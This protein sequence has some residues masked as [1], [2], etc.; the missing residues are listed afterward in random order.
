MKYEPPSHGE[1]QDGESIFSVLDLHKLESL[2][3]SLG[4]MAVNPPVRDSAVFLQER[5]KL[6]DT[7]DLVAPY[8]LIEEAHLE[9]LEVIE[10]IRRAYIP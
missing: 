3:Y 6:M 9:R 4:V 7:D 10:T 8:D 2:S 5:K 1:R